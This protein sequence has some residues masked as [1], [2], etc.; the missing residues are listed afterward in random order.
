MNARER[1]LAEMW[2]DA[3]R[4]SGARL[5]ELDEKAQDVGLS[6]EEQREYESV[7]AES[8]RLFREFLGEIFGET[9]ESKR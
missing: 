8:G 6:P 2:K 1:L 4:A 3:S 5:I 9:G 7:K